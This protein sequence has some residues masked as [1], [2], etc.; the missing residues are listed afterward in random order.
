ML[1][2][3][4]TILIRV[5]FSLAPGFRCRAAPSSTPPPKPRRPRVIFDEALF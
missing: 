1:I 4:S 3:N 5:A 2:R